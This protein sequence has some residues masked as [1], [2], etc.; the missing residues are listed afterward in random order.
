MVV[1]HHN[2]FLGMLGVTFRNC[3]VRTYAFDG[4]KYLRFSSDGILGAGSLAW[5][6]AFLVMAGVYW[7]LALAI[8]TAE[9][10]LAKQEFGDLS[11]CSWNTKRVQDDW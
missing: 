7:A 2:V 4:E 6:I 5:G 9:R 3:E 10:L 1:G 11:R 8:F